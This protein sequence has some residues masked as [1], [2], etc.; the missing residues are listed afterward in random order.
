MKYAIDEGSYFSAIERA[1]DII[2][3]KKGG[4]AC[5]ALTSLLSYVWDTS[6]CANM[7]DVFPVLDLATQE[8]ALD[9]LIGRSQYGRPVRHCQKSKIEN[10]Y[11]RNSFG[12]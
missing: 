8:I 9:L 12:T 6:R 2:V 7:G 3:Q 1:L 10:I 4:A 5:E 11:R